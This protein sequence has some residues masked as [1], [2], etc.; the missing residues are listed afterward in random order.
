VAAAFAFL[1]GVD[2]IAGKFDWP[3][4]IERAL[5]IAAC[6]GFF[7]ALLLAWYHGERGVQK[8]SGTEQLQEAATHRFVSPLLSAQVAAG[9]DDRELAFAQLH[10]AFDLREPTLPDIGFD[11][12]YDPI[13][14]DPRFQDLMKKLKLDVFFPLEARK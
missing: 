6:V 8:V 5:I 2:I 14:A 4:S 12:S 1:Q 11:F 7:I 3:L 9:L 10:K 13:R